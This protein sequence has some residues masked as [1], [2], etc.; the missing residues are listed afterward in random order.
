MQL[1]DVV[2]VCYYCAS[3]VFV[4]VLL[5]CLLLWCLSCVYRIGASHVFIAAS[6]VFIVLV[7]LMCLSL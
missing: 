5:M 3:H 2:I 6:R 7:L 4:V 1:M